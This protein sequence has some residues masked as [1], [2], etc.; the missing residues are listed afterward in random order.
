MKANYY[1]EDG[2]VYDYATNQ[3]IDW[4]TL[5]EGDIVD[6]QTMPFDKNGRHATGQAMVERNAFSGLLDYYPIYE[7]S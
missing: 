7:E 2:V 1:E 6:L 4:A 5:K 3:P